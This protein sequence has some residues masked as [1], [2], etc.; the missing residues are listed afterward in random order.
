MWLMVMKHRAIEVLSEVAERDW[1]QYQSICED[2]TETAC[3]LW[4]E[5]EALLI[6]TAELERMEDNGLLCG[7]KRL[8]EAGDLLIQSEEE[9]LHLHRN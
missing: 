8:L 3:Q 2:A 6:D 9:I 7:C 4:R 1:D 5:R